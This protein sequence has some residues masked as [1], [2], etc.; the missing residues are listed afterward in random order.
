MSVALPGTKE[1]TSVVGRGVTDGSPESEDTYVEFACANAVDS[2]DR[3]VGN[4]VVDKTRE[5]VEVGSGKIVEIVLLDVEE[6][7]DEVGY[8][9]KVVETPVE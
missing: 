3:E 2:V 4:S 7:S 9:C 1:D 6:A 5:S 8:G